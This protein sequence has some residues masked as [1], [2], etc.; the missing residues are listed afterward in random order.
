MAVA[1]GS[2]EIVLIF[3][4]IFG[5]CLVVYEISINR[6]RGKDFELLEESLL[7]RASKICA[8]YEARLVGL[9]EE[10]RQALGGVDVD[11]KTRLKVSFSTDDKNSI[12]AA[13]VRLREIKREATRI[14]RC[15]SM[16]KALVSR[17]FSR[18]YPDLPPLGTGRW[19][20]KAERAAI[21]LVK[22]RLIEQKDIILNKYDSSA[23]EMGEFIGGISSFQ[24]ELKIH[25]SKLAGGL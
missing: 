21:R 4:I 17:E 15:V 14:K 2:S 20:V 5:V 10:F 22:R 13:E 16:N 12:K 11:G 24:D 18:I 8:E 6:S 19:G 25:L 7:S 1:Q 9:T 23:M 3:L